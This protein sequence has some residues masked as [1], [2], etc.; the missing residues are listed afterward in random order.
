MREKQSPARLQA[1]D[2]A[3]S[4]DSD[5]DRDSRVSAE[6]N[7]DRTTADKQQTIIDKG[8]EKDAVKQTQKQASRRHGA[9]R[10]RRGGRL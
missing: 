5:I 3:Q 1:A 6:Y 4:T 10:L 9:P 7:R 8:S 2:T